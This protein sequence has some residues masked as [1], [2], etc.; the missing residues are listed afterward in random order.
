MNLK[1]SEFFIKLEFQKMNK[2]GSI[3]GP[4]NKIRAHRISFK[5]R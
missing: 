1:P 3:F 4:L 2:K 5:T